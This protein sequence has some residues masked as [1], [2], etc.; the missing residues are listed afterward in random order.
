MTDINEFLKE[1]TEKLLIPTISD[2][3]K[4]PNQSRAFDDKWETDGLNEKV[5]QY[6]IDFANKLQIENFEIKMHK[7]E[8]MT[9]V[10]LGIAE[11][12]D[13]PTILMYGHLDKQPLLLNN[14]LMVCYH[15]YL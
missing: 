11:K 8:K 2:F 3:I 9:P 6:A 7:D 5:C 13:A 1:Q 14:G 12:K 15:M 10:V 4:I